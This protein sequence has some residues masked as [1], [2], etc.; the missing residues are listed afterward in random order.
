MSSN[1]NNKTTVIVIIKQLFLYTF[2]TNQ[3]Y[4]TGT[5]IKTNAVANR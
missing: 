2:E 4:R 5:K 1:I 3:Q